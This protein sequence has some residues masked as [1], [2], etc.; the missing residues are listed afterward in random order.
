MCVLYEIVWVPIVVRIEQESFCYPFNLN[1]QRMKVLFT[2]FKIED[3][4]RVILKMDYQKS[5]LFFGKI[6]IRF[7]IMASILNEDL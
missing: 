3:S 6:S 2:F 5:G 7:I 1:Y 4:D